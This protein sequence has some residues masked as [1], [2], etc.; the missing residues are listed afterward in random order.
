[1][2]QDSSIFRCPI[3]DIMQEI[4]NIGEIELYTPQC[5]DEVVVTHLKKGYEKLYKSQLE[6]HKWTN[7][8]SG[9]IMVI[10]PDYYLLHVNGAYYFMC[11]CKYPF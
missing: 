3:N 9:K 10:D 11:D 4:A 8:P 5:C 7:F 1:M 6:N 2:E